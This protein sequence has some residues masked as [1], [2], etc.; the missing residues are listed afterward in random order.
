[1]YEK[2][3]AVNYFQIGISFC[4]RDIPAFEYANYVA[5]WWS[6]KLNWI[7]ISY[8]KKKISQPIWIRNAWFFAVSFYNVYYTIW[9]YPFCYHG[10]ILV[11]DLL[12]L[13]ALLAVFGILFWYLP[14]VSYPH[15]PASIWVSM[16]GRVCG[17]FKCFLN[18]KSPKIMKSDW[19]DW[20]RVSCHGNQIFSPV[21]VLP[22]EVLHYQ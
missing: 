6:H 15:D 20:K 22:V 17:L 4:S 5:K 9:V 1:M 8:N 11:P 7:L 10:N 12:I 3:N 2:K 14:I 19:G 21:G 13:K 18:T 16:L